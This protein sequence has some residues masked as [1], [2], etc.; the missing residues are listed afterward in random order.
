MVRVPS[1]PL[2]TVR[3]PHSIRPSMQLAAMA[4]SVVM[5]VQVVPGSTMPLSGLSSDSLVSLLQPRKAGVAMRLREQ[6]RV[7]NR[8]MWDLW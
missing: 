5:G 6:M 1:Q 7:R 4:A 2:S 8:F 3:A